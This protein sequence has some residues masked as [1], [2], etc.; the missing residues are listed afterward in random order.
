[1]GPDWEA[2]GA[3]ILDAVSGA[4]GIERARIGVWGVSLGGC[5]APRRAGGARRARACI[6]LCGPFS[7]GETWDRLPELTRDAFRVRSK[8]ATAGQARLR[9]DELTLAGRLDGLT[10]PLL[11]VAGRKDRIIPW[12]Q[13]RQ[14]A[15]E[16]AGPAELL[17]LDEGGHGC[18]KVSYRHPPY[19]ADWMAPHP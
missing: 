12:Q 17:L 15:D 11:V 8:S 4:P 5:V 19:S 3:A 13:A 6:A 10:A 14:L 2:P 9:A 1:M 7:F 18:A 16:A